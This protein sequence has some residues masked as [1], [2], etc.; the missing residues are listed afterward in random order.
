MNQDC[1]CQISAFYI[2]SAK[3]SCDPQETTDIIF[4]AQLSSTPNV[5]D[6]SLI[7]FLFNWITSGTASLSIQHV[8]LNIDSAC[9]VRIDSFSAPICSKPPSAT[10]TTQ[11]VSVA[12]VDLNAVSNIIGALVGTILV[13]VVI[14]LVV[15]CAL[16]IFKHRRQLIKFIPRLV[17]YVAMSIAPQD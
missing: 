13:A 8:D 4:R 9:D 3:F 14:V 15:I 10:F 1:L 17:L 11:A 2:T 16:H 6:K 5:S 7:N 12:S